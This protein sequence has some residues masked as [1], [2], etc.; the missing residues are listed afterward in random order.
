MTTDSTTTTDRET[1]IQG[2][3]ALADLLETTPDLALP[4][5]QKI[6]W[7]IHYQG[8]TPE[9]QRAALAKTARLI[10]GRL[11]KNDPNSGHYAEL[12]L[13]LTGNVGGMPIEIWGERPTVCTKVPTGTETITHTVPDPTV[14]VPTVEVTETVEKFEWICEPILAHRIDVPA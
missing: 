14:V 4:T 7:A 3:R 12:Y 8:T 13:V 2:L 6:E 10:P 5:T 9:E 1:Y 11:D